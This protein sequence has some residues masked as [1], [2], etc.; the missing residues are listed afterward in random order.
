VSSGSGPHRVL[1]ALA[2][3]ALLA[4]GC[5]SDERSH[6][7]RS[8]GDRADAT[9]TADAVVRQPGSMRGFLARANTAC[10]RLGAG[11]LPG[12]VPMTSK[13]LHAYARTALV[14]VGG[15]AEELRRL[16]A[17]PTRRAAVDRL[18]G[19]YQRLLALLQQVALG[20]RGKAPPAGMAQLV[21]GAEAGVRTAAR[22]AGLPA[23]AV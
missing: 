12:T 15:A 21:S 23:C 22:A 17:P 4:L 3:M 1:A 10:L 16:E 5:D 18:Q 19:E 9:K 13:R 7:G 2:A 8:T 20:A 14:R 6:A 11:S